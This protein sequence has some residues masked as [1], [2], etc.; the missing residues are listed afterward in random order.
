VA[1]AG[2]GAGDLL[3]RA[4]LHVQHCDAWDWGAG[5]L[6]CPRLSGPGHHRFAIYSLRTGR[7]VPGADDVHAR[8]RAFDAAADAY[9]RARPGYPPEPIEIAARRL[10]IEREAAVLDLGAGTGK[11]TRR[12]AARFASVTA[13]ERD[14]APVPRPPSR[15][16]A[17]LEDRELVRRHRAARRRTLAGALALNRLATAAHRR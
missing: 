3:G 6:E 4:E 2:E 5:G 9:E 11:L 8:A 14:L 17:G 7:F 12:L 13:V 1:L 15:L 10:G 16:H